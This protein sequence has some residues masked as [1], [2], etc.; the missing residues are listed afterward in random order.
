MER[1][2]DSVRDGGVWIEWNSAKTTDCTAYFSVNP[3]VV[4]LI[5]LLNDGAKIQ[6]V[7]GIIVGINSNCTKKLIKQPH[8][9]KFKFKSKGIKKQAPNMRM[10]CRQCNKVRPSLT[11]VSTAEKLCICHEMYL[12]CE[13]NFIEIV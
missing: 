3:T 6:A 7:K 10:M 1:E 11:I 4:N 9:P 5:H 12:K 2:N 13:G 8:Q